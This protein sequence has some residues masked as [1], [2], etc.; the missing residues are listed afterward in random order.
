MQPVC[1]SGGQQIMYAWA[2]NAPVLEMAKGN[3][4]YKGR[5]Y[6]QTR[7]GLTIGVI[8]HNA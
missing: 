1:A 6:L 4:P 7:I 2:K 3:Y 8:L 5:P